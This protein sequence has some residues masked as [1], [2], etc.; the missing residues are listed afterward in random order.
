MRRF[1][2]ILRRDLLNLFQNPMWIGVSTAFPVLLS[3]L[4]GRLG[5]GS[6]GGD[7][8]AYDYYGL[9]MAIYSSLMA[10]TI[11]S[12]S[13]MEERIKKA[14]LRVFYLPLSQ[15]SVVASKVIATFIFT[16]VC[17][18]AAM[19]FLYGVAKVDFGGPHMPYTVGL[20]ALFNLLSAS[21]GVMACCLF[22][23]ESLANQALGIVTTLMSISSGVFFP[24]YRAGKALVLLSRI[25]PLTLLVNTLFRLVYDGSRAGV[26]P[27]AILFLAASI[28][29]IAGA[30]RLFRMEDYI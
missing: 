17:Q 20:L 8:N 19:L 30:G 18:L 29:L 13:F 1:L 7:G 15:Y 3:L 9:S 28:G 26:L 2:I 22:R 25:S 5:G 11:G 21:V 23:S 12:N 6:S 10:C 14:N 4:L 16:S 24:V 27:A